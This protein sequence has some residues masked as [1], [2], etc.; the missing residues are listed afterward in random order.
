MADNRNRTR[1]L[2]L[3]AGLLALVSIACFVTPIYVIRPFRHQGPTELALALF[4]TRIGPWL[5]IVCAFGCAVLALRTFQKTSK[6][7]VRSLVLVAAAIAVIGA[8]LT[9][10]NV[11]E[12]LFHHLDRPEFESAGRANIGLDDMVLAVRV[13][14]M[15]RAY[16]IREIAYHHVVN[17]TV[18]G[19]PIVATY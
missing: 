1:P 6:W 14:G 17:D 12:L 15:D 16:P 13:Q 11:Y 10:V 3:S 7:A 5:S 19:E 8:W 4:I 9:R 2:V 18:R